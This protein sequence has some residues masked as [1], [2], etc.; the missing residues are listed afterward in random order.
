MGG[1]QK[2][3]LPV[4]FGRPRFSVTKMLMSNN[5]PNCL[6]PDNTGLVGTDPLTT[7]VN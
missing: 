7:G 2:L 4:K 3:D 1:K 6:C 5:H